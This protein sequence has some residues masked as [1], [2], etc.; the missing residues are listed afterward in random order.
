MTV[1]ASAP[2]ARMFLHI[3]D[4]DGAHANIVIVK[5]DGTRRVMGLQNRPQEGLVFDKDV[6]IYPRG[7]REIEIGTLTPEAEKRAYEVQER[8][9]R[10]AAAGKLRFSYDPSRLGEKK[11]VN[12]V[13]Y[14]ADVIQA[15]TEWD[16]MAALQK[17]SNFELLRDAAYFARNYMNRRQMAIECAHAPRA[18]ASHL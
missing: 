10:L 15:V 4:G 13:T 8:Y 6:E 9:R 7:R 1:P 2:S 16:G 5:P 17:N 18:L 14:S 12:C 3:N 11:G